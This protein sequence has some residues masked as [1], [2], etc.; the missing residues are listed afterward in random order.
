MGGEGRPIANRPDP[1][2]T[3][4]NLLHKNAGATNEAGPNQQRA[5]LSWLFVCALF[6][7]CGILGLLQYRWITAA[8][9][10]T[11]E[12]GL[13]ES[14]QH[15]LTRLSQD[16]DSEIATIMRRAYARQ[17]RGAKSAGVAE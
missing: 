17:S 14:L 1:E 13:R 16:F 2:G 9:V 10:T 12:K 11:R 5:I 7:L 3:P 6:V 8:S 15:G 4:A